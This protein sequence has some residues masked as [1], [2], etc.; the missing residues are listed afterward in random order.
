MHAL[1]GRKNKLDE[2][3]RIEAHYRAGIIS[4]VIANC[5]RDSKKKPEPFEPEDFMPETK[6]EKQKKE[7]T[8]EEQKEYVKILNSMFG[9]TV[10][11]A[12]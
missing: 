6:K 7:Q 1:I 9:G 10:G 8:T 12:D 3:Q 4:S 11:G 5:Y 2:K